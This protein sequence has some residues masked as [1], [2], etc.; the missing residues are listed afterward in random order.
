MSQKVHYTRNQVS[1]FLYDRF[2]EVDWSEVVSS[3]P[4]IIWRSRW[5]SLAD[6]LGL[7]Y[8]QKS[9]ELMDYKGVGPASVSHD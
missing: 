5:N 1:R 6:R 2:P 4:P 9:I 8:T 7:P 3:L